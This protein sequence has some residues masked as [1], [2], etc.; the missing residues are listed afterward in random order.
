MT[1]E[2]G[3]EAMNTFSS[4]ADWY[5]VVATYTGSQLCLSVTNWN[6]ASS[7]APTCIAHSTNPGDA[8]TAKFRVSGAINSSGN[9]AN[10]Y[11]G[12][13]DELGILLTG[14][15]NDDSVRDCMF[16]SGNG[17]AYGDLSTCNE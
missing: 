10:T 12:R 7:N 14:W 1:A 15:G 9:L 16:N 2:Q 6:D 3:E 11:V 13:V 5:Y 8:S 4:A 17:R